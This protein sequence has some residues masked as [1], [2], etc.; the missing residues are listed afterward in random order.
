MLIKLSNEH[1]VNADEILLIIAYGNELSKTLYGQAKE[2]GLLLDLT[3]RRP[4]KSLIILRNQVIIAYPYEPK[5]I[6][7]K[8]DKTTETSN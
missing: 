4:R 5:T 2:K 7:N 3:K 6:Y 8:I 1:Y